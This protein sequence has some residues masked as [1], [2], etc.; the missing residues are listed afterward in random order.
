MV[1]AADTVR[2]KNADPKSASWDRIAIGR[3]VEDGDLPTVAAEF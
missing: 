3:N 1:L 2:L